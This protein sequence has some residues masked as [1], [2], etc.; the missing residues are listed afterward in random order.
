MMIVERYIARTKDKVA[1]GRHTIEVLTTFHERRPGALAEVV[2]KL[3]GHAVVRTTVGRTVPGA[4]SATETF[5]IGID[6]GS[7]VSL[8]YHD[9]RPFAFSGTIRS[10]DV[11][12]AGVECAAE[13][14]SR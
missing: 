1:P 6:L 13:V 11:T 8:E 7:P 4:F 12:I 5:D 2:V 3:D 14:R 10:V 9:R